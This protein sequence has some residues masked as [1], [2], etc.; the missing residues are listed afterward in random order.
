MDRINPEHHMPD[1]FIDNTHTATF[2]PV[3]QIGSDRNSDFG[4][5]YW[6]LLLP[7]T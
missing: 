7:S 4:N 3:W 6:H 2:R 5:A 1:C